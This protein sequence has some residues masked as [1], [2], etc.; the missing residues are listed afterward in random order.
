MSPEDAYGR[1]RDISR[2]A[3]RGRTMYVIPYIM[4]TADSP[5]AMIGSRSPTR[6]T[7][8]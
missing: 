5:F 3:M 6:S 2:N 4:G 8:C 7:S 1:L